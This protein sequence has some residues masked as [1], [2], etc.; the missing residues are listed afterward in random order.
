MRLICC[1]F[2]FVELININRFSII[3]SHTD[4]YK[5]PLSKA[6]QGQLNLLIHTWE[7]LHFL[8]YINCEDN[9]WI[10]NILCTTFSTTMQMCPNALRCLDGVWLEVMGL[11]F[12]TVAYFTK[13]IYTYYTY[14][15]FCIN[16]VNFKRNFY[17][18]LIRQY[19]LQ[20]Y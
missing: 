4:K 18:T 7:N 14:I 2:F 10:L 6:Q 11:V 13:C 15:K 20:K 8:T 16:K 12:S 9:G 5:T 3:W 1:C 17:Y 19:V